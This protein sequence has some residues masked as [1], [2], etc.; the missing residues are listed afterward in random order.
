MRPGPLNRVERRPARYVE[1]NATWQNHGTMRSHVVVSEQIRYVSRRRSSRVKVNAARSGVRGDGAVACL[2]HNECDRRS[3]PTVKLRVF[4]LPCSA[5]FLRPRTPWGARVSVLRV[6][7]IH[8]KASSSPTRLGHHWIRRL[9]DGRWSSLPRAR[10][11]WVGRASKRPTD[12]LGARC[13]GASRGS[14]CSR[15]SPRW[16]RLGD[17]RLARCC[18]RFGGISHWLELQVFARRAPGHSHVC[19]TL[20]RGS[21]RYSVARCSTT[22][23]LSRDYDTNA[24]D[25]SVACDSRRDYHFSF[26]GLG[27]SARAGSRRHG[28]SQSANGCSMEAA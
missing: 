24:V 11:G 17:S 16:T 8:R 28:A 20:C 23:P 22:R 25:P 13:A 1:M 4:E 27:R 21:N 15:R 14:L 7:T 3:A 2:R 6:H 26:A 9:D 12:S 19:H 10:S 5:D 18:S